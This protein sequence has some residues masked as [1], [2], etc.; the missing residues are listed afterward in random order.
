MKKI[1]CYHCQ[2]EVKPYG[3][4]KLRF[5]S[6]CY[7]RLTDDGKGFY[8][9]CENCS[10]NMPPDAD[11]CLKC[12]HSLNSSADKIISPYSAKELILSWLLG[13]FAIIFGIFIISGILYISFNLIAVFLVFA[14]IYWLYYFIKLRF[15]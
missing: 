15:F 2:Q 3:F 13:I 10:A 8:R 7:R 4:S 12:G 11:C 14:A 9:V 5:C 1:F 6:Q